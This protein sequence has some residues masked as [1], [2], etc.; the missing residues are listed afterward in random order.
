MRNPVLDAAE[1]L[2]AAKI[3]SPRTDARILWRHAEGHNEIFQQLIARRLA[4]EPVAY[5]TG[6][7]EYWSLDFKVA[8]GVLIPR[9]ETE[10]LVEQALRYFEDRTR[11]CRL[12]DLGTGSGC[13]L[14]ALL[15]ELPNATGVGV[16][17]SPEALAVA[18]ENLTQH[19]VVKRATLVLG[20]WDAAQGGFDL[21][22]ANPP[23]VRSSDLEGLPPDIGQYE[24]KEAL[25]GGPDGLD[26]YR[27]L[28]PILPGYLC[29]GG[30]ALLEVGAGQHQIVGEIME[31]SGLEL[32]GIVRD[33][34]GIPRCL[35][36]R[37]R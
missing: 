33:L 7:K 22:A 31:A 8:S 6:H 11:P 21:V 4:Y 10:T 24:P 37:V 20:G 36:I 26:A 17:S 35:T 14:V 16:D 28:A 18:Q 5:I 29:A 12:L 32:A 25:D 13:L 27:S 3:Q 2:R 30:I 34:G 15:K 1:R 23:Y 9:P 19:D